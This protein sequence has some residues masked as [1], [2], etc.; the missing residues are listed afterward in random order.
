MADDPSPTWT[1][2]AR[3]GP[4]P[5]TGAV[6]T[7]PA[8]SDRPLWIFGYGSLVWRPAFPFERRR[9]AWLEGYVRR[10]WQGSTDHRGVPGAP[11]RV[12]TLVEA[13]GARCWGMAYRVAAERAG[14]VTALLDEREKGGYERRRVSLRPADG[15]PA[16]FPE[17]LVYFATPENPNYLGEAPLAAVA[18]QVRRSRG[19][20]GDNREYVLRLAASLRQHGAEDDHVFALEARVLARGEP[21]GAGPGE[22]ET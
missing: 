20:S 8:M 13:P 2:L 12:V 17:G 15:A 21:G 18:E 10:F 7:V 9:P 1:D 22:P 14:E 3:S 11:G 16:P 5:D 4:G 6:A 19:P